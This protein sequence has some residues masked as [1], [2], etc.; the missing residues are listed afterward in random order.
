MDDVAAPLGVHLIAEF[1]GCHRIDDPT[2]VETEMVAAAVASGATVLR[3]DVHDFGVALGVTGV[4][5]LAES[6][7]SIHTWPEY[8]YAAVDVFVC[9]RANPHI[10]VSHLERSFQSERV[11]VSKYERGALAF[12]A[13]SRGALQ[14]D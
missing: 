9:G 12:Q 6:H 5:L 10:A 2:F 4:V 8:A 11:E 1:Y 3:S 14:H 7:I 13:K